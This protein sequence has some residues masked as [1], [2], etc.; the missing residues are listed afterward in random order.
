MKKEE[1]K[2]LVRVVRSI[3]GNSLVVQWLGL[4]TFTAAAPVQSIYCQGTKI[5]QDAKHSQK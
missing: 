1:T 5:P 4:G 3:Q 2:T